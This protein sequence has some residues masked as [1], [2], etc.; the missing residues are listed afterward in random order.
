MFASVQSLPYFPYPWLDQ[1]EADLQS[2]RNE[3]RAIE[4]L[5][6]QTD[7]RLRLASLRD[8]EA[9]RLA[10]IAAETKVEVVV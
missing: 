1:L 7:Y 3:I 6:S 8:Q 5:S 4:A 2:V 9:K 10:Q